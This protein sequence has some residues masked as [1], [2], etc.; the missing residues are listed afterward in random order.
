LIYQA[1]NR[2]A[3]IQLEFPDKDRP[4]LMIKAIFMILGE[5]QAHDNWFPVSGK[6]PCYSLGRAL[7]A[8]PSWPEAV[9]FIFMV[10]G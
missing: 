10:H 5:P 9:T 2:L 8:R 1:L 3:P 4:G 7:S 6:K